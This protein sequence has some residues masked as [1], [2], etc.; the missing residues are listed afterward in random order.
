MDNMTI[1]GEEGTREGISR[2]EGE[3]GK[4]Q[5]RERREETYKT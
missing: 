1:S 3:R 4:R 2:V 5:E